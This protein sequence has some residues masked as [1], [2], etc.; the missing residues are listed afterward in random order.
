ME[1]K[2]CLGVKPEGSQTAAGRT[3]RVLF[4]SDPGRDIFH[5]SG[6]IYGRAPGEPLENILGRLAAR[7]ALLNEMEADLALVAYQSADRRWRLIRDF[8]QTPLYYAPTPGGFVWSFDYKALLDE[9][10]GPE[11]DEATLF[12]YLA[13]HYRH[14]FRDPARTFH[15]GVFQVPAGS[16][17]DIDANGPRTHNWLQLEH[18]PE[19]WALGPEEATERFMALL[20][21][22]VKLR[23]AQAAKPLFT[24]SSGLDS[25]TVASLAA[26]DLGEIDVFSV[27][28]SGPG[29]EEYDETEGVG[30]LVQGRSWR[31]T[32]LLMERPDL[33]G[34]TEKLIGATGSPVVTVTWLAYYLMARQFPGFHHW[35]NGI[36]GDE[37]LA[38]EFG[39]FF[40]FF[41]DLRREGD[42]ERLQS[43]V[44]AWSRLHDHPVFKKNPEVLRRFWERNIDFAKGEIKVDQSLYSGNW[45]FFEPDWLDRY[46][47][48][49]PP[50]PRP[51][52]NFLSNRLWQEISYE[53]TPPTFWGLFMANQ[54]LGL[55]GISPMMSLPLFRL[56][57]SLPGQVKY[58]QGLTKALMRRGLKSVLPESLRLNSKKT[59]FNAPIQ[60][61][62]NEPQVRGPFMELLRE[63]PLAKSGWLRKGAVEE[64]YREHQSGQANHMMLL[65]TLLNASLF[66]GISRWR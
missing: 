57:L 12:D 65:W 66:L 43:E 51:F 60:Q 24:V 56:T 27:G 40:Y 21:R 61:W 36:G 29:S 28:Y 26:R 34:E 45:R 49:L 17:V 32:H 38:G 11:P 25:S 39:H 3:G 1:S 53:T 31:W 41:A 46:R 37:N 55:T 23:V 62:F 10:G 14:I 47:E 2:D 7:P 59:G 35:F 8:G 18:D 4:Q 5:F 33:V 9:L 15:R 42:E 50:M 6:S 16:Y 64:I 30:Q 63:G 20:E 58:D 13:T 19:S 22:S 44:A 54:A 52:P 48:P